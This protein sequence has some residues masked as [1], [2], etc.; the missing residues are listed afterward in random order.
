M[1]SSF[2]N[3]SSN[4][5]KDKISKSTFNKKVTLTTL[6]CFQVAS[7][8]KFNKCKKKCWYGTNNPRIGIF[9]DKSDPPSQHMK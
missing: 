6:V 9:V 8:V 3:T 1:Y 5:T 7:V 2:A 4:T